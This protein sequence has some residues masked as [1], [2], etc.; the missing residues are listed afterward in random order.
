MDIFRPFHK[1]EIKQNPLS[2]EYNLQCQQVTL[3]CVTVIYIHLDRIFNCIILTDVVIEL[4]LA[5]RRTVRVPSN[6]LLPLLGHTSFPAKWNHLQQHLQQVVED[7]E[8]V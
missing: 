8:T 5:R 3:I 7:E 6:M 2:M 1:K 4:Q